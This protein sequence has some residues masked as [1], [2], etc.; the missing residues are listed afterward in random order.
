MLE[1]YD[2]YSDAKKMMIFVEKMFKTLVKTV[3]KKQ[4]L[5]WNEQEIDFFK[6]FTVISYFDL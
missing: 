2:S 6:K 5:V 3:F 1:F 4:K